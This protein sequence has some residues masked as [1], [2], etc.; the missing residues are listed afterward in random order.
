MAASVAVAGDELGLYQ[1]ANGIKPRL[2]VLA[3][4]QNTIGVCALKA[5]ISI[6]IYNES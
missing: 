4:L 1:L 6:S 2:S 5:I 3:N